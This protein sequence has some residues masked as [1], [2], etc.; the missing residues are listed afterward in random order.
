MRAIDKFKLPDD[1]MRADPWYEEYLHQ[2]DH[3]MN[4]VK[5]WFHGTDHDSAKNI[6]T[7]GI[8]IERGRPGLDFSDS[9]GFYLTR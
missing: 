2:K 1:E 4:E 7:K 5:Y 3:P 9:N 8:D 6:V